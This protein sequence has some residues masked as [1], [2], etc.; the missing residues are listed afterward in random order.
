M[1]TKDAGAIFVSLDKDCIVCIHSGPTNFREFAF[2]FQVPFMCC[3]L[4]AIETPK[5]LPYKSG[6]RQVETRWWFHVDKL[7]EDWMLRVSICS[8]FIHY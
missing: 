7:L 8:S 4:K 5:K 2:H 6:L 1:G 3:L